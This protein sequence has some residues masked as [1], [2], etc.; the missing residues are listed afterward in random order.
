[1]FWLRDDHCWPFEKM[2]IV[3]FYLCNL[4]LHS[5]GPQFRIILYSAKRDA[6]KRLYIYILDR[7]KLVIIIITISMTWKEILKHIIHN[8]ER[9]G[10]TLLLQ[11]FTCVFF[12][13]DFVY[14]VYT[15]SVVG[16]VYKYFNEQGNLFC[17][18]I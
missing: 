8:L 12:N 18:N 6:E 7:C 16:Y 5:M 10:G 3:R 14:K 9:K 13:D 1:M 11:L 17:R 4:Q 15:I 2:P